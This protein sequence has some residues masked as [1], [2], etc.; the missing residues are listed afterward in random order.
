MRREGLDARLLANPDIKP[1][2]DKLEEFEQIPIADKVED[3]VSDPKW[4]KFAKE[5]NNP[6]LH[7]LQDPDIKRIYDKM[8][9]I[10][11]MQQLYTVQGVKSLLDELN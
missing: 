11:G 7:E 8:R 3:L 6:K 9:E 2:I 10:I 1:I 5:L 4:D